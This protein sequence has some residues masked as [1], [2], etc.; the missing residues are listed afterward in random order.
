MK[1]CLLI[2]PL[3]FYSWHSTI[4]NELSSR[5]FIVD[6]MNDEYPEGLVGV[7]LGNFVNTVS[8]KITLRKFN[9]Y[10]IKYKKRY[11]LII[12]FKGRGVS[13]ELLELI[14]LYSDKIVG[15][16][17][18]S[19][20]YSGYK[21]LKWFKNVDS[22]KTFD[23]VD[24]ANYN[25]KRVDLFSDKKIDC[26]PKK[27]IDISCLIRNYSNRLVYLDKIY[28][29][30]SND[31]IFKVYIFEKNILTLFG[32]ILQHPFL[33]FKWR[34]HIY[35]KTSQAEFF[36]IMSTSKFTIDYVPSSQSG[37]TMRCFQAAAC[38]TRVITNNNYV[39]ETSSLNGDNFFIYKLGEDTNALASFVENNLF[40]QPLSSYRGIGS[41][42][43]DLL[44]QV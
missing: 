2:T 17:F 21:Q 11:D 35:F 44:S 19:F 38:G 37:V 23:F 32:N 3:G 40:K 24:S 12:I 26:L 41:F 1:K 42:V 6:L 18:D 20:K 13:N 16:N 33:I 28:D 27:E 25:I 10:F 14:S 7:L 15:Y 30:F 5:G 31:L 43:D 36:K 22:Y 34:K 4:A 9:D 39:K 29:L 8:Q